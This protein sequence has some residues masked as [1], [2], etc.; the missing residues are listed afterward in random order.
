VAAREAPMS[1]IIKVLMVKEEAE[2]ILKD[3][4]KQSKGGK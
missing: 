4:Q 1:S 3:Y 2:V